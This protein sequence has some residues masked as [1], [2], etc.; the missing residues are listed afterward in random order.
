MMTIQGSWESGEGRV[1]A[2][3]GFAVAEHA[4]V[5]IYVYIYMCV[6]VYVYIY[7]PA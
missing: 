1:E 7:M 6:Y 5:Y 3:E 2:Q 4:R